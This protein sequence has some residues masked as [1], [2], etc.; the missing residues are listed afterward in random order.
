MRIAHPHRKH[1]G[2][3]T[4]FSLLSLG[5]IW[6]MIAGSLV[7]PWL[8]QPTPS[9]AS[10]AVQQ[11]ESITIG[12]SE[13][14]EFSPHLYA[15]Y[16]E[17]ITYTLRFTVGSG[18]HSNIVITDTFGNPSGA[19]Y[20][21]VTPTASVGP[22][23][24]TSGAFDPTDV[25]PT[26]NYPQIGH[27]V[28]RWSLL[29]AIDNTS[30]GD[31]VYEIRYRAR[32]YVDIN[33]GEPNR[34]AM[35]TAQINWAQGGPY[36]DAAFYVTLLQPFSF[37]L[38]KS[39]QPTTELSPGQAFS[40]TITMRNPPGA[41]QGTAYDLLIT[42]SLPAGIITDTFTLPPTATYAVVGDQV[43]F[44]LP[45]LNPIAQ[46]TVFRIWAHIPAVQNLAHGELFNKVDVYRSSAPGQAPGEQEYPSSANYTGLIQ[47]IDL[48]KTA[49]TMVD[50]YNSVS[51][52]VGGEYITITV[53][54]VIPQGLIVYDPVVRILLRDGMTL[55]QALGSTPWPNDIEF[56][57]DN[58]DLAKPGGYLTQYEW[59]SLD[60]ITNTNTGPVTLTFELQAQ[61]RQRY[62]NPY[63]PS[64]GQEIIHGTAME[65]VPIV[66]WAS[67]PGGQVYEDALCNP[68][69]PGLCR[70]DTGGPNIQF[71]RPDLRYQS[72]NSGSWFTYAGSFE[73][74]GSLFFT[75]HLDNQANR[76]TA[77]DSTVK[78]RL[79]P[80]LEYVTANPPPASVIT[81]TGGTTV[82]W[83]VSTPISNNTLLFDVEASLPPTMAVGFKV[84]STAHARYTTF[85]GSWPK[86]ASYY[87]YPP[88]NPAYTARIV[89]LGG[90]IPKKY[91]SP[92][93]NVKIGDMVDYTLMLT[94]NP[95]VVMY[96]PTFEDTMP[97]GFHYVPNSFSVENGQL[98][99]GSLYITGTGA[100]EYRQLIN[101]GLMTLDNRA[102]SEPEIITIHYQGL[103]KGLDYRY[104]GDG[105]PVYAASRNDLV[106]R[107]TARN[108]TGICWSDGPSEALQCLEPGSEPFAET[109][110]VQPYL[111]D[112]PPWAKVR[113][114]P[115]NEY[116]VGD[117]VY[118][119]VTLRNTGQGT[120]YEAILEDDLPQGIAFKDTILTVDPTD[121]PVS[122]ISQ[123]VL[124][125]TGTIS[126]TLNQIAPG[127]TVELSY[128]TRV[129]STAQPGIALT[130]EVEI[131]DYTSKPNYPDYD[132]HYAD[133]DD[134]FP[135][136]PIPEPKSCSPFVVLGVGLRK[137]DDPD[138]VG[139]GETLTYTIYF[140]NT[141]GRFSAINVRITDTYDANLTYLGA[142]VSDPTRIEFVGT[143]PPRD[144]VW[145]V[146]TMPNNDPTLFW[147]RPR[148]SVAEPFDPAAAPLIN[149]AGVDGQGDA[150][151]A[152][153]RTEETMVK[154]PSLAIEKTGV[155]PA[156]APGGKIVYT[157]RFTN[158][159]AYNITATNVLIQ[160]LY[161]P[162]VSY[163]SSTVAPVAG[164]TDEWTWVDLA[165]GDSGSFKVA[166][167]VDKPLPAGV[168]NVM[169]QARISCDEALA[170]TSDPY[171]TTINVP[172][173]NV[174]T[175]DW[176]DPVNRGNPL[177]YTIGY[178]NN[179]SLNA[180]AV[181]FTNI[182]D[183]YVNFA[184]ATPPP[185][186]GS[187]PGN[188]CTW[189]LPNLNM[190]SFSQIVIQVDVRD[191]IPCS[192][193]RLTNRATIQSSEVGP[194]TD[195]EYTTLPPGDCSY[196]IY[197]P[198]VTKNHQ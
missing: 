28:A 110:V 156:V 158:T 37:T 53:D 4:L 133:F 137:V 131:V 121:P 185:I 109:K 91:V 30:G 132:R 178:T 3:R 71:I 177:Q 188:I 54:V 141:S 44:E 95:G 186:G 184:S 106:T 145:R 74:G 108:T 56:N 21:P 107:L 128:R 18:L 55:T 51:Q 149:M 45:Y 42:D 129:T 63:N 197:I 11:I 98:V 192:V 140:S 20:L 25:N 142:E 154:L 17:L 43:I 57:P 61:A 23:P 172:V 73:G 46:D 113:T 111:A 195:I 75:L 78:E 117:D 175:A 92:A 152:V 87:D 94:V 144:I 162:N 93:D 174:G 77:Y 65:L 52:A 64:A 119:K 40:W 171:Q 101:W 33:A 136:D 90:F 86:E 2:K 187:C 47:N 82:T 112:S 180:T 16:G 122:L 102:G 166:V 138:P 5:L 50:L 143:F 176:P 170:V 165:P 167:L 70:R 105:E 153:W 59:N 72:P 89:L 123:P 183:P 15:S 68:N 60:S 146:Y 69:Q 29:E 6:A 104:P 12:K 114:D 126:W 160:E 39:Q 173:L 67:E 157:L 38:A 7:G 163:Y 76:P 10:S 13:E 22:I 100:N 191:E 169:N 27:P 1:R 97:K 124:N 161:D 120:A 99:T 85:D 88:A 181:T 31:W 130:N 24:I 168:L 49:T 34:K 19:L 66:R 26:V 80:G 81:G 118:F 41:M 84:T 147:I 193:T 139:P 134:K 189:Y 62:F 194:N 164:T 150:T 14:S 155:P 32:I 83:D 179:G 36:T 151:G 196:L 190:G 148:F 127:Q 8:L 103:L 135:Q 35:S 159:T 115:T 58:Q 116:E 9:Q 125:A 198:L 182:L 48:A 79:S 96:M